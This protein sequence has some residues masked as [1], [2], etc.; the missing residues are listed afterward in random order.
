MFS[1]KWLVKNR[2][3]VWE[4][5]KIKAMVFMWVTYFCS[6]GKWM[7]KEGDWKPKSGIMN[8]RN[9]QRK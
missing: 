8:G 5:N 1:D 7:S 9:I 3:V 2:M 6:Q 4:V